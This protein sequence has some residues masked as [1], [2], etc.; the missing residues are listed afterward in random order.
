MKMVFDSKISYEPTLNI[1][2]N[3]DEKPL[4]DFG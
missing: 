4:S 1:G 2:K 3:I